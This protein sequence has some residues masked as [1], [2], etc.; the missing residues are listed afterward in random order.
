M[1]GHIEH[2]GAL[3]TYP[4]T[5]DSEQLALSKAVPFMLT[6]FSMM[7]RLISK[8]KWVQTAAKS[9]NPSRQDTIYI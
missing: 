8:F 6:L 5:K 1:T 3:L 4:F 2:I 9:E 7:E